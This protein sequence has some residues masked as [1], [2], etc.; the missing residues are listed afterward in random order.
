MSCGK[1]SGA[2]PISHISTLAHF[3]IRKYLQPIPN[4]PN[5]RPFVW[6]EVHGVTGL[7]VKGVEECFDMR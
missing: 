6:G 1:R 2:S 5:H 7:Y 3:Q 4:L